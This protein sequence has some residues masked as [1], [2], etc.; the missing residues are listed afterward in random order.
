MPEQTLT[1]KRQAEERAEAAARAERRK[2]A[3]NKPPATK[4]PE[5]KGT[6]QMMPHRNRN[7]KDSSL[8]GKVQQQKVQSFTTRPGEA[9]K[10]SDQE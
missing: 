2:N 6:F 4:T 8:R 3:T 7:T 10:F 1:E 5:G 9:V